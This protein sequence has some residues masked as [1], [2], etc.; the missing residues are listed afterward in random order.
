MSLKTWKRYKR[1]E[2]DHNWGYLQVEGQV[3]HVKK[4]HIVWSGRLCYGPLKQV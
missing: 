2:E 3:R 4:R 1:N